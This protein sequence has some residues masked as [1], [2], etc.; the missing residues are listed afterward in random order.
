MMMICYVI[1]R[2]LFNEYV[3]YHRLLL[4]HVDLRSRENKFVFRRRY[5]FSIES[6]YEMGL[7]NELIVLFLQEEEVV[8]TL[9]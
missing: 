2:E 6:M 7:L 5:N 8:R 3:D 1:S 4:D 9:S